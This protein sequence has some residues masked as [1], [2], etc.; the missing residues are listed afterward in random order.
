MKEDTRKA[1][2]RAHDLVYRSCLIASRAAKG[3]V[4]QAAI[5]QAV[6]NNMLLNAHRNQW[7]HVQ[8]LIDEASVILCEVI[9]CKA[10][11]GD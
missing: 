2:V 9:S 5:G 7:R 10:G 3:N 8:R 1:L 4:Y 6:D 11:K